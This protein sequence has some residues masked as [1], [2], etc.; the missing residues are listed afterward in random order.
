MSQLNETLGRAGAFCVLS[1]LER[2]TQSLV[3]RTDVQSLMTTCNVQE[4][5]DLLEDLIAT[6]MLHRASD[7]FYIS[8]L[9]VR[10]AI[11]LRAVNGGELSDTFRQLSRIDSTLG[12]YELVRD[13][14]T[15]VFIRSLTS[16]PGI[17]ALYFCSPWIN[18][19]EKDFEHIRRSVDR[20]PSGA[21][22]VFV[23][24]RPD[25]VTNDVPDGA[26][27]F[28]EIGADIFLHPRLHTKLYIREPGLEGGHAMAII[29]SENLTRSRYLELGIKVNGDTAMIQQLVRYFFELTN[30]STEA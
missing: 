17:G 18:V 29:G 27:P 4:P 10:T 7:A 13:K 2:S 11:L 9:G 25:P 16:R 12:A 19:T 21:V 8:R 26:K 28:R 1:R 15:T 3:K 23:V 20:E 24:T 14:M 6:G 30:R 22:D 5:E